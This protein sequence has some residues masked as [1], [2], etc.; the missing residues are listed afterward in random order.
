MDAIPELTRDLLVSLHPRHAL[1]I[2][3]G[4]KTVELRRRFTERHTRGDNRRM[5]GSPRLFLQSPCI[6]SRPERFI[7]LDR[8]RSAGYRLMLIQAI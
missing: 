5:Y 6:R 2:L 3:S 8:R 7:R 4:E 1:N